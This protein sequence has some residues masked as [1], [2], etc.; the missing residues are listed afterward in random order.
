MRLLGPASEG[1][2]LS[3]NSDQH[4]ETRCVKCTARGE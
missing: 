2:E 4:D 3:L 1:A